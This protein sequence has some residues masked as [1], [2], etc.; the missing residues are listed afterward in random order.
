MKT[1]CIALLSGGLDSRLAIKLLQEQNIEVIALYF[2]LPFGSGCCMP[3][4]AFN[5]AQT[6]GIKLKVIDCTKGKLFQGYLSIIRKPKYG[7]G[8]AINPCID[9]H[10]FMLKKAKE[11]MPKFEAKFIATGEVLNERPM[12]QHLGALKLVEKESCLQGKLLRPLSAKLLEE[13]EAEKQGLVDRNKL[14]G[15]QGRS[16]HKQLELAK[17]WK[18]SFP[19]PAG[20]CL[21]CE[22]EFTKKL[23]DL[24]K[25]KKKIEPRDIELL[26]I[27]RHFRAGNN[28][29]IVGRNEQENKIIRSLANQDFIFEV[30]FIPSPITLL[31]GKVT[32][33]TIRLAAALTAAYSDAKKDR[34][35]NVT[36]N[37]GKGKLNKSLKVKSLSDAE[38]DKLRL[39]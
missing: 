38:I 4:C 8:S 5:F 11:L 36:V 28:K 27:G 12:S 14:L 37:Y 22:Q 33:K 10:I 29:I 17:R 2:S 15:I 6:R 25:H 19:T 35:L 26:K 39:K 7:Y 24:F 1:K 16:R 30:K 18:L 31:Q 20:G 23:R 32:E 3:D 34:G 9:C 21:L 13:T